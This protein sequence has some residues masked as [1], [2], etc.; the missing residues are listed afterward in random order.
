VSAAHWEMVLLSFEKLDQAPTVAEL[1]VDNTKT[2]Y[3]P[4][5]KNTIRFKVTDLPRAPL[6]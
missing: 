4:R 6:L 3:C 5:D 1:I 2:Q